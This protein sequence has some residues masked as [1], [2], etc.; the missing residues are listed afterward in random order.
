MNFCSALKHHALTILGHPSLDRIE[1]VL[2]EHP[3]AKLGATFPQAIW[4]RTVYL[5]GAKFNL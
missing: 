5:E 1:P 3:W 4:K 2:P